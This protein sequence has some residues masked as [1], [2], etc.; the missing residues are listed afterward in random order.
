M[1][2]TVTISRTDAEAVAALLRTARQYFPKSIQNHDTFTLENIGANVINKAL[3]PQAPTETREP[4]PCPFCKVGTLQLVTDAYTYRP[5][6]SIVPA[7][8]GA[9]FTAIEID[10]TQEYDDHTLTCT[11]CEEEGNADYFLEKI[12]ANAAADRAP[13]DVDNTTKTGPDGQLPAF[14]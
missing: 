4:M 12:D 1:S 2:E 8:Y 13:I 10:H 14:S 6:V 3:Q 5:I 11:D 7:Q 9:E